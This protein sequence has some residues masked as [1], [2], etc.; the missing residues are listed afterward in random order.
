MS[1]SWWDFPS[2]S[3]LDVISDQKFPHHVLGALSDR[4]T[5]VVLNPDGSTYLVGPEQALILETTSLGMQAL[6]VVYIL[7]TTCLQ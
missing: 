6:L 4:D 3:T 1:G 7:L 5:F 2:S